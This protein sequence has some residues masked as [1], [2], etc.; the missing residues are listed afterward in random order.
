MGF[1][2]SLVGRRSMHH[3]ACRWLS[4]HTTSSRTR[5]AA[6]LQ[7]VDQQSATTFRWF[8]STADNDNDKAV[9]SFKHK[10]GLSGN[11]WSRM[12]LDQCHQ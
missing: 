10:L 7:L 1:L 11:N 8:S 9:S 6:I 3:G 5:P 12:E 2:P 4:F